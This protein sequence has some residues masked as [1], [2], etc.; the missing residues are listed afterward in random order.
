MSV[1]YCVIVPS[2][3]LA[4]RDRT[5]KISELQQL[6]LWLWLCWFVLIS[7]IGSNNVSMGTLGSYTTALGGD[8]TLPAVETGGYQHAVTT[9]PTLEPHSNGVICLFSAC[10]LMWNYCK[11]NSL[12]LM[13]LYILLV[14]VVVI[15][16]LY[17][18]GGDPV[19]S[20]LN[21][22]CQDNFLIF[23]SVP[24]CSAGTGQEA[25]G[26]L[27]LRLTLTL[28]VVLLQLLNLISIISSDPPLSRS[29]QPRY[30][31]DH[32]IKITRNQAPLL[33]CP[34]YT[35]LF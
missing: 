33:Y 22:N 11:Y 34:T 29:D 7:V 3:G 14:V 17:P 16:A 1:L 6:I 26:Y 25:A 32:F 35:F 15:V 19:V 12:T 24:H 4:G 9:L 13:F 31:S 20:P 10:V 27:H 23:Q 5:Y 30:I 21:N 8:L 18:H 2:R 28:T